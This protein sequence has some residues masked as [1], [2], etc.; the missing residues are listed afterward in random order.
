MSCNTPPK[1]GITKTQA[2]TRSHP[3]RFLTTQHAAPRLFPFPLGKAKPAAAVAQELWW[4]GGNA[5]HVGHFNKP[6]L[7][8]PEA[9][10]EEVLLERYK[11]SKAL[12]D[13]RKLC[14]NASLSSPY[15]SPLSRSFTFQSATDAQVEEEDTDN[16]VHLRRHHHLVPYVPDSNSLQMPPCPR[17]NSPCPAL[18]SQ[19]IEK[20]P[21]PRSAGSSTTQPRR[22]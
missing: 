16:S 15:P 8:E 5:P 2:H 20:S 4:E 18:T 17:N 21:S 10:M 6:K 7:P 14:A 22:N 19:S 9:P 11:E 3:S 1:T 12:E 13:Q